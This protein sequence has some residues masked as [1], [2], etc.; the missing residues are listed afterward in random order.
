MKYLN[1]QVLSGV[2]SGNITGSAIDCNQI[3]QA[4]FQF[5]SANSNT[6]GTVKI[7]AS[8][9]IPTHG[10]GA[11]IQNFVPTHWIDVP[12]A[13]ATIASGSQGLISMSQFSFRWLRVVFT[14]SGGDGL[15]VVCNMMALSV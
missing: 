9:D 7:Q 12:S 11:P 1:C 10:T 6:A 3:F 8:N 2:D 5:I 4:S 13:T 14:Q 15:T